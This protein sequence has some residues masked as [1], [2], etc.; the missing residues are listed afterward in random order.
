MEV[1]YSV[2]YNVKNN[3]KIDEKD[4]KGVFNKKLLNV[5][6]ILEKGLTN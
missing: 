6:L 4:I 3:F 5:I 1:K 2:K